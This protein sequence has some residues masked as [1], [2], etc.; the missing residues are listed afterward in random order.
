MTNH[1]C[2][3]CALPDCDDQDRKCGLRR[4]LAAYRVCLE[5]KMPVS[6]SVREAKNIAYNELYGSIQ[7]QRSA[8]YY[9]LKKA[10]AEAEGAAI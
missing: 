5:K 4:A 6:P 1:P 2:F 7:R 10:K 8:R 3:S 9:Q